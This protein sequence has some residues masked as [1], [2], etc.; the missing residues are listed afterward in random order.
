MTE[1]LLKGKESN[2]GEIRITNHGIYTDYTR[3]NGIDPTNL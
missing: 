3:D 2:I 1:I